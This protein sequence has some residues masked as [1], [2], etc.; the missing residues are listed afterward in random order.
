MIKSILLAIGLLGAVCGQSSAAV[1]GGIAGQVRVY[2][3]DGKDK[4]ITSRDTPFELANIQRIETSPSSRARIVFNDGTELNLSEGSDFRL[5]PADEKTK[6]PGFFELAMGR[7]RALV[8]K[9]LNTGYSF[10][11]RSRDAVMGVRGTEF[12]VEVTRDRTS[13]C[14][15]TGVVEVQS[16]AN[17]NEKQVV[18]TNQGVVVSTNGR[19]SPP[20]TMDAGQMAWWRRETQVDRTGSLKSTLELLGNDWRWAGPTAVDSFDPTAMYSQ[21]EMLSWGGDVWMRGLYSDGVPNRDRTHT[22][23]ELSGTARLG[24][25]ATLVPNRYVLAFAEVIGLMK[26]G[27]RNPD[28]GPFNFHQGFALARSGAGHS[29]AVGRQEWDF[30]SGLII[31]ADRWSAVS[32]TFDGLLAT[33]RFAP[34]RIRGFA[35][36]LGDRV[37]SLEFEDFMA[38]LYADFSKIPLD[39]YGL[40]IQ[41]DGARSYTPTNISTTHGVFGE[42]LALG[43]W[44]PFFVNEEAAYESGRLNIGNDEKKLSSYLAYADAGLAWKGRLAGSIRGVYLR[45]SGDDDAT[46]KEHHGFIPVFPDSHRFLGLINAFPEMRNI[47]RYGASLNFRLSARGRP[48]TVQMDYSRF[49]RVTTEETAPPVKNPA[50]KALGDEY[51]VQLGIEPHPRLFLQLGAGY[52]SP[53]EALDVSRNGVFGFAMAQFKF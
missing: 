46:D 7:V 4:L 1:I 16:R 14:T 6:A 29:V 22:H 47:E 48:L 18:K 50:Q 10:E 53:N 21:Y 24:L 17:P 15:F 13:L 35:T 9:T 39:L 5:Q 41:R 38:G 43:P 51:D 11:V 32:R 37:S 19:I 3:P 23:G 2:G 26:A 8:K 40:M 25:N 36:S 45:A 49:Q 34:V 31:G 20:V 30:G 42:R 33:L 52:L 12:I 28:N 44:G 27:H